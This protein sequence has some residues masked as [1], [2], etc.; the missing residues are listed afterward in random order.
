MN[1]NTVSSAGDIEQEVLNFY[2][3]LVGNSARTLRGLDIEVL[4]EGGQI[5]ADQGKFH[6]QPVIFNNR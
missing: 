4:R 1:G 6:I 2:I 5:T 3:G